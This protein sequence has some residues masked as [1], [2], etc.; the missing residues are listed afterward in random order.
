MSTADLSHLHQALD[1][2]EEREA[3]LLVWGDTDG[4]FTHADIISLFTRNLPYEDA[5]SLLAELQNA[6]MLFS[7]PT[8]KGEARYRTRMAESVHLFRHQRQWFRDQPLQRARTLV[9]DYR[10]VRRPRNYPKQELPAQTVLNKWVD[11]PWMNEIKR[12]ALSRLI[13]DFSIAGFQERST[14]RILRAWHF[15]SNHAHAKEATGTIVCAGTGSG[16]TLAFYLPALTSLLNDIQ[17][18][19]AQRVRTLALYP[20]KE[21]LKDQFMETWGK[22]RELDSQALT[23]AGRKIRIGSFF[24]DTP[25]SHQY[26]TKDKDKDMPF[27]LLRCT[28]PK[29][30]GQMHWKAEDIKLKREILRCSHCDHSVDSDEV[31]LTR[32]S[33]MKNPPDILFTTTEML[34]QHLGNNQANQLFGIGIGVTPPPVVLLDE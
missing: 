30:P 10:F 26:A 14:E 6:A 27:D 13:G 31:I 4:A 18:D 7:V 32:V 33:L 19:N 1:L 22:C 17:R 25:F 8:S 29:C 24:G 5:E 9:A 16:K 21:L 15:H 28:T 12:Q 11:V 2:L 23:L 20:R 3:E 34:N